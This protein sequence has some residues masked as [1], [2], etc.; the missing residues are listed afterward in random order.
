MLAGIYFNGQSSKP[1]QAEITITNLH[2]LINIMD[3]DYI[4]TIQ[5]EHEN[6][7]VTDIPGSDKVSVKYGEF[8]YQSIE[9]NSAAFFSSVK[10]VNPTAAYIRTPYNFLVGKSP[11]VL[12]GIGIAFLAVILVCYFFL[13]PLATQAIVKAIPVDTEIALGK[14]I[15]EEILKDEVVDTVRTASVNRF[16]KNLKSKSKYPVT[17]V[18]V[19]SD[20]KNAFAMPGGQ[21]VVYTGLLKE[22]NDYSEL[23]ALL[24]HEKAH[25]EER[26]SLQMLAKSLG[27]YIVISLVFQDVNGVGSILVENASSLQ[28][29][30][31]SRKY[32]SDAD[33][34]GLKLML[35]NNVDPNGMCTLFSHLKAGEGAISVPEFLST[36]PDLNHRIEVLKK[37]MAKLKYEIT[38]HPALESEWK[39]I[40]YR[41]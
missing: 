19:R 9:L 1:F 6:V 23:V 39:N 10:E 15:S 31:Y 14:R 3:G 16:Y 41:K 12:I 36:H 25:I 32:E 35:N 33:D 4:Q 40:E 5:W 18:V 13:L 8:P 7:H 38:P 24:G 37:K 2:I 22:M 27:L 11:R 29:L 17:I 26:H 34:L 30:S 20:I 21:I 28:Q